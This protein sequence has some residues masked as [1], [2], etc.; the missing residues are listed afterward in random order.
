M[1]DIL[2]K[3]KITTRCEFVPFSQSR[4]K[5]NDHKS[6]NWKATLSI[7]D[8]EVLTIDYMQGIGHA[9]HY[10]TPIRFKSGKVDAYMQRQAEK[11]E[12][13]KGFIARRAMGETMIASNKKLPEPTTKDIL[14]SL[15]MDSDVLD[16]TGFEDWADCLGYDSDSISAKKIYEAC[17]EIALKIRAYFGDELMRELKEFYQ[18]Y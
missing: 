4:N 11:I 17:M 12:C 2:E 7:N 14:Y 18:D 15:I 13:E 1:C 16:Y 6:L 5:D 8:K 10:K 9:P 3:N